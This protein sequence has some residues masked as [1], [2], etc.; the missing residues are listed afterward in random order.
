MKLLR[1]ALLVSSIFAASVLVVAQG[2]ATDDGSCSICSE[3]EVVT[4]PDTILR[5][6]TAGFTRANQTCAEIEDLASSGSYSFNQCRLL[7]TSSVGD[8]CG[9][10]TPS[11]EQ[12]ETLVG[13][14]GDDGDDTSAATE[15]FAGA[16]FLISG[17]F[18]A[19]TTASMFC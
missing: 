3:G 11:P 18:A 8:T 10:G 4:N 2:I 14:T 12:T 17:V 6:M 9:C 15:M 7:N 16:K 1:N 19:V 5:E 13:G